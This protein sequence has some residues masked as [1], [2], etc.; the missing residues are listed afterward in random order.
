MVE[1]VLVFAGRDTVLWSSCS[2]S[3]EAYELWQL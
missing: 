2:C 3:L 1:C